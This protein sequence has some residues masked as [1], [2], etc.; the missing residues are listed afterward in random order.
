MTAHAEAEAAHIEAVK[1][2]INAVTAHTAPVAV[3]IE[4]VKSYTE[5]ATDH[6]AAA[7]SHAH[8][9]ETTVNTHENMV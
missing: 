4:A 9:F 5:A 6:I 3:L 7:T 1:S 2:C 8:P